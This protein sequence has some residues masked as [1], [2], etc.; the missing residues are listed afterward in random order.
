MYTDN[1]LDL[2]IKKKILKAKDVIAFR[3][4]FTQKLSL[5]IVD[6]ENFKLITSFNDIFVTIASI[7]FL[8]SMAWI[9]GT[10]KPNLG[11]IAVSISS[12][13]LSEIFIRRKRMHKS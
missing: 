8:F 11:A 2:A 13:G 7:L 3:S 9:L 6:E 5:D 4:Y 10:I 1:D 12:W